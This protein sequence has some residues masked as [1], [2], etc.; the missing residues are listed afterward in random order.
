VSTVAAEALTLMAGSTRREAQALTYRVAIAIGVMTFTFAGMP[1]RAQPQRRAGDRGASA[2]QQPLR[3]QFHWSPKTDYTNDPNGLVFYRGEYH[4]FYQARQFAD[5]DTPEWGHAVS[6]DLVHWKQLPIAIPKIPGVT[7]DVGYGKRICS[8]SAVVDWNNTSGFGTAANP[9]LVAMFTDP[10]IDGAKAWQAQSIAYSVDNGRTWTRYPGNPVIDIKAR[11]FRDPKVIWYEPAKRWIAAMA[12]PDKGVVSLYSSP[13]LREWT[14]I[15]DFGSGGAEC[16]DMFPMKADTGQTKW[17]MTVASGNYWVGEFDGLD[18]NADGGTTPRGRLDYGA[19][20]YAFQTFSDVPNGRRL[21]MAWMQDGLFGRTTRSGPFAAMPWQGGYTVVRELSLKTI[22][23]TLQLT[24]EPVVEMNQLRGRRYTVV[25]NAVAANTS[26]PLEAAGTGNQLDIEATLDVGAAERAGLKVLVGSGQE[27]VIGYD[28]AANQ[29]YVDKS[30]ADGMGAGRGR[31]GAGG[32]GGGRGA[33]G[34]AT[35]PDSARGK[36][37]KFRVLVDRSAVEVFADGGRTMA[38]FVYPIQSNLLAVPAAPGDRSLK[39]SATGG[40]VVGGKILVNSGPNGPLGAVETLTVTSI[41][42]PAAS[43]S[44]V[45]PA[46]AGDTNIR[47]GNTT[48]ITPGR[49][50]TIDTGGGAETVTVAAVG[51]P[52]SSPTVLF[53]RAAAGDTNINVANAAGFAEGSQ[54][55]I[56]TGTGSEVR[57]VAVGGVGTAGRVLTLAAPAA[58]GAT[59]IKVTN[60]RGGFGREGGGGALDIGTPVIIGAGSGNPETRV[61]VGPA[62]ANGVFNG[63][64]GAD[65]T[66]VTLSAPLSAAVANGARVRYAGTGITLTEPLRQT[67]GDGAATRALGSGVTLTEPLRRGH[68]SDVAVTDPGGGVGVTPAIRSAWPAGTVVSNQPGGGVEMFS[69]GGVATMKSLDVW[70]VRSAW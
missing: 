30:R 38:Y 63:T 22:D 43:A 67:H 27:M 70:Q 20:A 28:S 53:A 24:Q 45:A 44:L 2:Y 62:D 36:P 55:T 68:A 49:R 51:S 29:L 40:L 8:G 16:P 41:G 52:A 18:F 37:V 11:G 60:L 35:L 65:G 39:V 21:L 59:N 23:G 15:N 1:G 9:P 25:N 4:L 14:H 3:P 5:L 48:N 42:T 7:E 46:A 31:G 26:V 33:Q 56:D 34:V 57:T 50:L 58:A 64:A 13:N 32:F 17:V 19:N 6:P 69:V 66:G 54:V 10:C 61:I 47:L 12:Y